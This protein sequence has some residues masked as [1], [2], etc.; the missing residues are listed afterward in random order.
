[1]KNPQQSQVKPPKMARK[2]VFLALV[3]FLF[4]TLALSPAVSPP[5]S[6]MTGSLD[7]LG[8]IG[9]SAVAGAA[10]GGGIADGPG[11]AVGAAIGALFGFFVTY[12]GPDPA[13]N[14]NS[15]KNYYAVEKAMDLYNLLNLS[16]AQAA[17][18]ITSFSGLTYFYARK[19]EF[20]AMALYENQTNWPKGTGRSHLFEPEWIF[21]SADI[22]NGSQSQ[23]WAIMQTYNECLSVLDDLP[24][25]FQGTY[26][27]M[28]YG[29]YVDGSI[30]TRDPVSIGTEPL[31]FRYFINMSTP[32]AGTTVVI[33]PAYPLMLWKAPS[34]VSDT[35]SLQLYDYTGAL[36]FNHTAHLTDDSAVDS[37]DLK[38]LGV[39][40]G[41]YHIDITNGWGVH[42]LGSPSSS[43][44]GNCLPMLSAF[45]RASSTN[46]TLQWKNDIYFGGGN[47]REN[48][49]SSIYDMIGATA[50]KFV[51]QGDGTWAANAAIN[52]HTVPMNGG[53]GLSGGISQLGIIEAATASMYSTVLSFAQTSY[54]L[55]KA[56]G[57]S[58]VIPP[59]D[60]IFPDPGQMDGLTWQQIY[61]MYMA[62]MD[63]AAAWYHNYSSLDTTQVNFSAESMDLVIRAEL[64]DST[65][66]QICDNSTIMTPYVSIYNM[67]LTTGNWTNFTQPGFV[68]VWGNTSLASNQQHRPVTADYNVTTC[69][70]IKVQTGWKIKPWNMLYEGVAC[71]TITLRITQ[72]NY[73]VGNVS[74]DNP[75]PQGIGDWQWILEHWYYIGFIAAGALLLAA[76]KGGMV[77][78]VIGLIVLLASLGGYLYANWGDIYSWFNPFF[79]IRSQ[80]SL[81][82]WN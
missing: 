65:G 52:N 2:L 73:V 60:M 12:D 69:K 76:I 15:P 44:P 61:L 8:I 33:N 3:P 19:A 72:L 23:L 71:N 47:W 40:L 63:Q 78:A 79:S 36:A 31:I 10:L 41:R 25:M 74:N 21:A 11:A 42:G 53:N 46:D 54:N 39:P 50:P 67:T 29:L 17:N 75:P 16:D 56:S 48:F 28:H 80:I 7:D 34:A 59:A 30:N 26:N 24:A 64:K 20:G 6:A 82:W 70:F 5:A 62:Y 51:F 35:Y 37:L 18:L 32:T 9:A 43:A 27:G 38:S 58:A 1:M 66:K 68:M 45:T 81:W 14:L 57:G 13:P 49:W 77:V 4:L 22:Y 55:V